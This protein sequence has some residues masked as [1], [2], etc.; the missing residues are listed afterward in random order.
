VSARA[1]RLHAVVTGGGRGIGAAIATRLAADG[2]AV[3]LMG[4]TKS[5]LDEV[6]AGIDESASIAVDVGDPESVRRAFAGAREAMGPVDILV[7]NAG[8][9]DSAPFARV[10]GD[11]WRRMMAVNLDGVFHACSEVVAGM[12]ERGWGRIVNIAS[13]AGLKGYPYVV[14]YCAAKHGVVGLTRSLALELARTGVTVNAVC[15]GYTDT[16]LVARAV[17]RIAGVGGRDRD[18]ALAALVA[19]NPQGRLVQPHEVATVV[20]WLVGPDSGSITGQSLAVAG[21]EV[22]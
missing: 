18:Q 14:A 19:A 15:P 22:M 3:T 20:A 2:I 10:D 6:A 16:E 8:T 21:G 12:R 13:T 17:D 1:A 4:R 9:A 5:A 11:H 7:N